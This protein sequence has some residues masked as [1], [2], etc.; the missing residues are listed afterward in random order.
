MTDVEAAIEQL[1]QIARHSQDD[2]E[3]AHWEA[4]EVL[5]RLLINRG[6]ADVVNE[7]KKVRKYYA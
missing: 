3:A 1:K 6:Y 4:D 2:P 7:W 5:C